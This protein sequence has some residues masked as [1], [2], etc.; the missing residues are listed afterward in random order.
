MAQTWSAHLGGVAVGDHLALSRGGRVV[1]LEPI[2]AATDAEVTTSG[3]DGEPRR[4]G[5]D[6]RSLIMSGPLGYTT[7]AVRPATAAEQAQAA[8]DTA[9]N[10][11]PG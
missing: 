5:R 6:T 3:P 4:Y 10:D 1:S 2:T 8:E 7:F 9:D 11:S